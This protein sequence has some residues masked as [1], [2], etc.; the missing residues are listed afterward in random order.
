MPA[1]TFFGGPDDESYTETEPEDYILRLYEENDLELG[2]V[3]VA[4]FKRKDVSE[5]WL[6]NEAGSLAEHFTEDFDEEHGGE[7]GCF[8]DAAV[9]ALEALEAL[10]LPILRDIAAQ[11]AVVW[12]CEQVGTRTW[13]KE[14]VAKV[15]GDLARPPKS[16]ERV[17]V[18][19]FPKRA[20]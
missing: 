12:Q 19:A 5:T 20:P 1:N 11:H 10:L 7:D 3:E 15:V 6:R 17:E 13:T 16:L 14:E 2:E 18:V 8:K 9:E 4:E